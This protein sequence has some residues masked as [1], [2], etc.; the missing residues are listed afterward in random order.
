MKVTVNWLKKYV[1]FDWDTDELTERLTMLGLE[2]EGVEQ[3]GGGFEGVVVAEVLSRDPHPN[4]DRLSVCRVNDGEGERQIVCGAD[5]FQAGDKVPLILPGASLPPAKEGDK[6]FTIKV[7]KIRGVESKGMMCS[8]KELGI[9]DDAAGLLILP[10]EATVGQPFAEHLGGAEP[11]VVFDLEV[12]PNRPDLNSVIGIAREIAAL[13]GN[14]LNVPEAALGESNENVST[15]VDVRIEDNDLCPRYTARVVKGVKIG[16]SPDWLRRSLEAVGIRSISN[17]VDVTNYVMLEVGQPLHA[18]DYHLIAK[19]AEGKPTIVVRRANNNEKFT[20]LDDTEHELTGENLLIADEEKGIALAGVMGGLNT[21]INDQTVDVLIES[22]YFNPTNIRRTSKQLNL[23]TDSSYRFERGADP[24]ISEWS[25]RRAAQLIVET[26]GGEVMTGMVDVYASP[27]EPREIQLRFE[28]TDALLGIAIPAAEQL[29]FLKSLELSVVGEAAEDS[30]TFR[31]P[32]WR[33]DLKRE[34]DLIEEVA[35]LY[36]VDKVPS[37][38]PRGAIGTNEFDNVYDD[39]SQVRR[40]L[41]GMGLNETQGQTLIAKAD[42]ERTCDPADIVALDNPLSSDMDVLRPSLLPGLMT[43]LRHNAHH[44]Q[45]DLAL[46]EIGRVF[47]R[48]KGE[49]SEHRRLAMAI[50]GNRGAPFW[51][52]D[53]ENVDAH[54]LKGIVDELLDGI[55]LRG[56]FFARRDAA[57]D[58]MVDSAEVKL[59]GKLLLGEMGQLQP[60]IARDLDLRHPVYLAEFDLDQLLGR[61]PPRGGFKPLP[62]QP[63]I[64]RDIAMI[65]S[66]EIDHEQIMQTVK[67]VRPEFLEAVELFD[68]FRGS[69]IPEGRKSVAYTLTYRHAERTLKD[70]E[71][72]ASHEKVVL[73]LRDKLSAEIREN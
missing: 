28:R 30:A 22:A 37:T 43:M 20:T 70:K 64:Q 44:R 55:G 51:Q 16:P 38:P 21:E 73:A 33:V 46:F 29:R 27:I 17:V 25:S 58:L 39:L 48:K 35:R 54:D 45:N 15:A 18:F 34:T 7:G 24:E 11:D 57:T 63:A 32:S 9:S 52:D 49:P 12:T 53:G 5:N 69:N 71:A 56:L 14:P 42:A 3:T 13:T 65:V 59:G 47:R 19:N 40:L 60:T 66:E 62:A 50:T 41:S 67:K 6:P 61:R 23:R 8:P 1:D 10:A 2:V 31:I 26:A 72:N 4:A 36:G 68:V